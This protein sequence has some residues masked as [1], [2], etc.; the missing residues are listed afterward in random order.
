MRRFWRA[1]RAVPRAFAPRA[2]RPPR[3]L[4]AAQLG[5]G[6]A[7]A[8]VAP[9]AARAE[10]E[11]TEEERQTVALFERCSGAVVHINTFAHQQG[12]VMGT[13]GLSMASE[14]VPQGT[15]SGFLWDEQH[16][17][18]NFHVIKDADRATVTFA[19]HSSQEAVL[20][21]SEP[22]C[23]LAVLRCQRRTAK[24]L[25]RASSSKLQVGQKVFAIGNPFGLD[26]TLT[27]GI[28]SG[29]GREMRSLT[30]R[31]MRNLVQTNAAINPG[32]SGG[33][34]LDARGRFIGVNT[35]IA[36]PSGAFAGVGFA[37][38]SDTVARIVQQI[39]K[40]GHAKH[41]YMGL[42]LAPDQWTHNMSSL[43]ERQ[44]LGKI[45]GVL[46]LKIE[47]GS[48]ADAA[49]LLPT[50]RAA[51]GIIIG[52]EL[53]A[54]EGHQVKS[55]DD[56]MELVDEKQIGETVEVTFR[57]RA[58]RDEVLKT[59]LRLGERPRSPVAPVS[60]QSPQAGLPVAKL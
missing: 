57:R 29:V 39:I 25:E 34:L 36:S 45:E 12:L 32:N 10:E 11:L 54:I 56:L 16:I 40:Y 58:E 21:G 3:A 38:P 50:Y 28:I 42:V 43:T 20:V 8:L 15:G 44:G 55:M 59:R 17:V 18:T 60:M 4:A 22:D 23:D 26:Q 46:V 7:L 37:I 27:N 14:E 30:G 31:M 5:A 6:A 53:L 24:P 41:A 49:G 1:F 33:P 2:P 47:P 35:M 48:P 52:D 51:R 9:R 13:R 19:D